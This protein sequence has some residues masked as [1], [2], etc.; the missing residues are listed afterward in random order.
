MGGVRQG[1]GLRLL[2]E[3]LVTAVVL[4]R[5][6]HAEKNGVFFNGKASCT[7]RWNLV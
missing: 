2:V 1:G 4:I 7:D 5:V 3:L 6:I